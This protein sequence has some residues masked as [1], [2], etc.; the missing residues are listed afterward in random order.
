MLLCECCGH[1]AV[2]RAR[3]LAKACR[4]RPL[5]GKGAYSQLRRIEA[6]RHPDKQSVCL[7]ERWRFEDEEGGLVERVA[8][9]RRRGRPWLP[10]LR[11]TP[12]LEDWQTTAPQFQALKEGVQAFALRQ[13]PPQAVHSGDE[14]LSPRERARETAAEAWAKVCATCCDCR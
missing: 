12:G 6:G 8:S 2:F 13:A 3:E 7:L 14:A 10:A 4:G 11:T 5:R 9:R 1:H